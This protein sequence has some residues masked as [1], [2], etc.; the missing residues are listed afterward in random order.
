MFEAARRSARVSRSGTDS[1]ALS[2]VAF[3]PVESSSSLMPN[4][5][6]CSDLSLS[7]NELSA[8]QHG[9][10]RPTTRESVRRRIDCNQTRKLETKTSSSQ[11]GHVSRQTVY[12]HGKL[13]TH[14][15]AAARV[16]E[17]LD[18]LQ[19]PRVDR[20]RAAAHSRLDIVSP[21]AAS[22]P[23]RKLRSI[24]ACGACACFTCNTAPHTTLWLS[25]PG[26]SAWR[27]PAGSTAAPHRA[28]RPP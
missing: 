22:A 23:L 26:A 14:R 5:Q 9:H 17:L 13:R 3:S 10:L 16:F 8:F 11:C 6:R 12:D 18:R 15:H 24:A 1:M 19:R 2:S 7:R 21:M 20:A 28:R 25:E 4:A 27:R